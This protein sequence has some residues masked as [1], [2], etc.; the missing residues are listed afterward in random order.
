MRRTYIP[1]PRQKYGFRRGCMNAMFVGLA[2][3]EIKTFPRDAVNVRSMRSRAA[4]LNAMEGK[5]RKYIV[6]YDR[7]TNTVR[8]K[9]NEA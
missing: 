2:P 7:L 9:K 8:I 1:H 6:S 5:R 4:Q 3:G